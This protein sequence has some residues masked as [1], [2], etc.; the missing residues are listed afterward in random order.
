MACSF[1]F[2]TYELLPKTKANAFVGLFVGVVA[3]PPLLM[4]A[5]G[6]PSSTPLPT[7]HTEYVDFVEKYKHGLSWHVLLQ[8]TTAAAL[9][10]A[11]V[12]NMPSE[13]RGQF[14]RWLR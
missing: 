7:S 9:Y 5:L 14:M 4:P 10:L 11:A 8:E 6:I 12:A 3:V 13:A 2:K 1:L